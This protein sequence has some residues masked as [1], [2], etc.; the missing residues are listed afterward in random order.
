MAQNIQDL[1][2]KPDLTAQDIVD[3]ATEI[4]RKCWWQ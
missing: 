1:M 2:L 4:N 3:R